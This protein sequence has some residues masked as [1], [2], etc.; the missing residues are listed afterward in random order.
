MKLNPIKVS[1]LNNYIKKYLSSNALLNNLLV[2]GEISNFYVSK[3]GISFFSLNDN[4][5]SINCI[6]FFEEKNIKNGDK[7]LVEG[8][9]S[10]YDQK[11]SYQIN[12]K[13]IVHKGIGEVLN[14]LELLKTKLEKEGKF[15]Q[16]K[17]LP[18][19]PK[20]IGIITSKNG[21]AIKD[22]LKVFNQISFDADIYIYNA[23][24]QGDRSKETIVNGL[25]YFNNHNKTDVIM[26][27][28]GGGSFEDLSVFN[29]IEIAEEIYKS[30]VP[31]VT[32]IGH[33][34]DTT[35]SDLTADLFCSTPTAA[36]TK[37]TLNY[38]NVMGELENLFVLLKNKTNN[39]MLK[40]KNA[41]EKNRYV[42]KSIS[43]INDINIFKKDIEKNIN[44]IK[45]LNNNK[46]DSFNNLL[47]LYEEKISNNNYKNQL[48]KGYALVLNNKG[49][50]VKDKTDLDFS[51]NIDII[52]NNVKITANIIKI[53]GVLNE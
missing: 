42:I 29:N 1:E 10:V 36:A 2:E 9:L 46:I 12:V 30:I 45:Q 31:V 6:C 34:S 51:Q 32:G 21:A 52:L 4:N 53:E 40:Y 37:V 15:S 28:R 27:C 5:S 38:K 20:K 41:L 33:E 49:Y 50:I 7:V 11:G 19:F 13:K 18:L 39:A 35:L 47:K 48:K 17:P 23:L 14:K 25:N 8:F 16:K 44:S 3:S 26:I 43:P 22:I 24:V